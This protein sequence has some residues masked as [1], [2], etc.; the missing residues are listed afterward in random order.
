MWAT[1]SSSRWSHHSRKASPPS[2]SPTTVWRAS[3]GSSLRCPRCLV[4]P[5]CWWSGTIRIKI[6]QKV[7]RIKRYSAWWSLFRTFLHPLVALTKG[8]HTLPSPTKLRQPD[9][10]VLSHFTHRILGWP[11][12]L[13][14]LAWSEPQVCESLGVKG[15]KGYPPWEN[16]PQLP[17]AIP[18]DLF[19]WKL[20]LKDISF[21]LLISV[22]IWSPSS[23]NQ[24]K[25]K[26]NP[27]S[28]WEVSCP[29]AVAL[30]SKGDSQEPASCSTT[31]SP[32]L[33]TPVICYGS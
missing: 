25:T 13:C 10:A 3:S 29:A 7:R 21:L 24:D 33:A 9:P 30:Q 8:G 2:S 27:S 4:C 17:S 6:P 20:S 23:G 28:G 31:L 32:V 18:A 12:E 26:N 5:S 1:L 16:R 15:I 11:S 19:T 14:A 22:L